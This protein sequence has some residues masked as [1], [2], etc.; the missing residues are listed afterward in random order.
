MTKA[1]RHKALAKA[2]YIG[3]KD[4]EAVASI[5]GLNKR[6]INN[7]KNTS[8][9]SGDDWDKQ[10]IDKHLSHANRDKDSLFSDFVGLMYDELQA[11]RENKELDT[12]KRIDAISKLGDSFSKMRRIAN[13]ENP[14]AY[15]R[16][17]IKKTISQII[18]VIQPHVSKECLSI[19]IEQ[20]ELHQESLADVSV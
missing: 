18:T 2:L 1:Q 15:T 17:L 9:N 5:L 8:L 16:T 19:I 3:G 10:K 14:E 12:K 6:T 20:I 11:I 7:Y 4:V 13:S